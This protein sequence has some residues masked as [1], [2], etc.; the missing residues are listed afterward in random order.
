[1]AIT[2][3]GSY[4]IELSQFT[5][6][7]KSFKGEVNFP[8][9]HDITMANVFKSVDAGATSNCVNCH[10]RETSDDITFGTRAYNSF[11]LKPTPV[12]KID[13]IDFKQEALN[14]EMANDQSYRCHLIYS[15]YSH[16]SVVHQ[17]FPSGTPTFIESFNIPI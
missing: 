10:L 8:L 3:S 4:K 16:G 2:G 7:T 15:I 17:D 11:A 6:V 12:T 5:E 9:D 14:C 1:M 13:V